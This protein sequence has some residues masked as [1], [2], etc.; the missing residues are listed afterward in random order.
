MLD[1][2]Q[3]ELRK[4]LARNVLSASLRLALEAGVY[5]DDPR[6]HNMKLNMKRLP[7]FSGAIKFENTGRLDAMLSSSLIYLCP[8]TIDVVLDMSSD[9]S[10]CTF[11][12]IFPFSLLPHIFFYV[13]PRSQCT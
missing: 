7:V 5:Q 10:N 13:L 6:L 11:L 1:W 3:V 9:I 8:L 4:Y 2:Q 12:R